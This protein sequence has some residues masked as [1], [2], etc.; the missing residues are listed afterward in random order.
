MEKTIICFHN[1]IPKN[2]NK[3]VYPRITSS[4]NRCHSQDDQTR[5]A[6][7]RFLFDFCV[8]VVRSFENSMFTVHLFC[9]LS[10]LQDYLFVYPKEV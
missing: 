9:F 5:V 4:S 2:K 6:T 7:F 8:A 10:S 1:T 3:H